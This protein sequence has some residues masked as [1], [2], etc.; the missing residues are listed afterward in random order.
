MA[1]RGFLGAVEES[2]QSRHDDAGIHDRLQHHRRDLAL[3]ALQRPLDGLDLVELGEQRMAGDLA[4]AMQPGLE[5]AIGAVIAAAGLQDQRPVGE[6][7][8]ELHRQHAGLGAGV[9]EQHALEGLDPADEGLGE[10]DLR[11]RGAEPGPALGCHPG[12]RLG[13]RRKGMAVD[14]AETVVVQIDIAIAVDIPEIGPLAALMDDGIGREITE[15]PGEP[16]GHAVAGPR[17]E[18]GGARRAG[19]IVLFDAVARHDLD[20]APR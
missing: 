6:G 8:G 5:I 1:V 13:H 17:Q 20:T 11:L 16:A 7:A 4:L 18:L 12:Q 9:R 14:Q 19:A 10:F 2:R 15:I 3:V